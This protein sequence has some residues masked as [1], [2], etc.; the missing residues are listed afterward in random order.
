MF[1]DLPNLYSDRAAAKTINGGQDCGK[2]LILLNGKMIRTE[3]G[4]RTTI[5][6][7]LGDISWSR[8]RVAAPTSSHTT[9]DTQRSRA[10]YYPS[11]TLRK[12]G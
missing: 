2:G 5:P 6:S 4:P 3:G 11:A 10:T 7:V 8:R 12:M 9:Y 1:D